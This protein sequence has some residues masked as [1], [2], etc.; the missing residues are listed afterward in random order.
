MQRTMVGAALCL[1]GLA[2]P[3]AV[4]AQTRFDHQSIAYVVPEKR[5]RLDANVSDPKGVKLARVYFKTPAQADYV[6]VPMQAAGGRY[7][8]TLP[9]MNA[10]SPSLEYVFLAVNNA[11]DVAKSVSYTVPAR[12]ESATPAWQSAANQ[13]EMKVYTEAATAPKAIAGF[14]DSI[15]MDVAESTARFGAAAGLLTTGGGGAGAG[16]AASASGSTA[17]TTTATTSATVGGL[18]T[19]AIVGGVA[20][21]AAAAAAAGSGGGGG[22]GGSSAPPPTTPGSYAGTWSGSH[23]VSGSFVS[24]GCSASFTCSGSW[25]ATVNASGAVSG[26][27]IFATGSG[28]SPGLVCSGS[29]PFT[30]QLTASGQGTTNLIDTSSGLTCPPVT[31][32]FSVSPRSVSGTWTCTT[33]V[34]GTGCNASYTWTFSGS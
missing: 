29:E 10:S 16:G 25:N 28:S 2:F 27:L 20:V 15:A 4:S 18:S 6:Y 8:A 22:G 34:P 21:A 12:R 30:A 23:N 1:L 13:G 7:S 14:S 9:A 5:V 32:Q 19:A 3:L 17:G 31:M 11:G 24:G 26:T 33:P